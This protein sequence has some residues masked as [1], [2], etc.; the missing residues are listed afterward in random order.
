MSRFL[1]RE[2][3]VAFNGDT[4]TDSFGDKPANLE[5][6]LPTRL[7]QGNHISNLEIMG[8]FYWIVIHPDVSA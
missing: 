6:S 5:F 4:G 7:T 1:R 8:G 2:V 3:Q